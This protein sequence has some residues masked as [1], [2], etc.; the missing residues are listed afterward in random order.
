MRDLS[1]NVGIRH[2]L[3]QKGKLVQYKIKIGNVDNVM[4]EELASTEEA[5]LELYNK[6]HHELS[7]RGIKLCTDL[8]VL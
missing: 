8:K 6:L 4:V 3:I 7:S 1:I 2:I 5:A